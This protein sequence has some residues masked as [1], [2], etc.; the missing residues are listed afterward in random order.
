[1]HK[2]YLAFILATAVTGFAPA[3]T[4]AQTFVTPFAGVTFNGDAPENALTTGVGLTFMGKIA[5][6]EIDLGYTPDFFGESAEEV[7]IA[8]S[9]ITTLTGNLVIG[10]G[11]GPVRPYGVVGVGLMRTRVEIDDI[12][13]DVSQNDVAISAGVGVIGMLGERVGLRGDVRYFRSLEDPSDDDDF[14]VSIGNFDFWRATA[15]VTFKF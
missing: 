7:L 3:A 10:V 8:D 15:G 14:D 13:D 11:D 5:G 6:F 12:F 1:M 9:N 4:H 2:H